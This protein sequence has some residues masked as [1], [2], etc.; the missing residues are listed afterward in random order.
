VPRPGLI[1]LEG[2]PGAG[3]TTT[4][5]ELAARGLTVIGEYT[6]VAA[7]TLPVS[8]HPPVDNDDAHQANW[9]RKA[10]QCASWLATGGTVYADRDWLSSLSYAYSTAPDDDGTL[11]ARRARWAL[12]GLR[13]SW[14]LLPGLYVLFDLDPAA[15]LE[16]RAGRFRPG[17]PWNDPGALQRLRDFYA[18]PARAIAPCCPALASVLLLPGRKDVSGY[19]GIHQAA[20]LLATMAGQP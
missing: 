8:A 10:A 1:V 20:T 13:E 5:S 19:D 18:D 2:M 16:R 17:H 15:S 14:L 4:A 7:E 11:L 9:V 6:S 12:D 3:K